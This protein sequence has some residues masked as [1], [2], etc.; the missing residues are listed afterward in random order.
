MSGAGPGGPVSFADVAVYFS[1]EE[2]GRLRPAQ[3]A[4]YRD[5]MRETYGHLDVLGFPGPKPALISWM[6]QETWDSDANCPEGDWE[7]A[8]TCEA[9]AKSKNK[10]IRKTPGEEEGPVTKRLEDVGQPTTR[11]GE[12][13]TQSAKLPS[14]PH[15][16]RPPTS[17]S[18]CVSLSAPRTD[19]RHG[20]NIC[21]KHFAWRS[22]LVEHIY[23]HTGEKP[24]HCPDCDKGFSQTSSLSKHRA[25]HRGE[26][27]HRCPDCGRAFTQ[28]SA[29][30]THLRVH[31]GEKP[32]QCA[33]CGRRFS[34]SSA[35]SQH[36]RVHSGETP[37]SCADCGRAFAHN[38]DLRRHQ[39]THTGEKP[40]PCP[41]CGRCFRQS[42][43]MVA[44]RRTHSGERPY[45]CPEC[46]RR[47]SQK[48]AV[49]KH[50]WIHRPGAGG[51]RGRLTAVLPMQ[52][53]S[54][55]EDLDPPVGFQHYPE[56]FQECGPSSELE[57]P[58]PRAPS[59]QSGSTG[60]S[61]RLEETVNASTSRR[62][63]GRGLGALRPIAGPLRKKEGGAARPSC[64][65]R[66]SGG[67]VS[68]ATILDWREG[69]APGDSA[70]RHAAAEPR[71]KA[72]G[73][74][75]RR[76][77]RPGVRRKGRRRRL[78][79]EPEPGQDPVAPAVPR[80]WGLL[81]RSPGTRLHGPSDQ[82]A[83][84][85]TA[86]L[87]SGTERPGPYPQPPQRRLLFL[88]HLLRLAPRARGLSGSGASLAGS[89][90]IT[91]TSCV[92][93][94]GRGLGSR[95]PARGW[96]AGPPTPGSQE[97]CRGHRAVDPRVQAACILKAD[98]GLGRKVGT[99]A[100]TRTGSRA[101]PAV[102]GARRSGD[103]WWT[104]GAPGARTPREL[105][106]GG[107]E[108]RL[109]LF[110]SKGFPRLL[111]SKME[112]ETRPWGLDP[113]SPEEPESQRGT[114]TGS[115][116]GRRK[117]V[118]ENEEEIPQ[119]ED[120]ENED[121]EEIPFGVEPQSPGFDEIPEVPPSPE[122][123][124]PLDLSLED[125]PLDSYTEGYEDQPP[126]DL[127][128]GT[129][130][131][132][133]SGTLLTDPRFEIL[134]ENPLNL[135]E[136]IHSQPRRGGGP[137][138]QGRQPPRPN[139]CGICGKSFGRGSTLIQHQ[140]IHTG[141]KPYK[142][143]VCGKAFSQSSDLIKHQRTH[144]GERP[145]KCPR[146]G[147]AFA[148]SSYLL[149]HQRTHTGQKPYKCPYCGKAFGD[150]S[151]LLRHQRTH[152][153]ERP[154]SCPDCG[155]CYSQNSSLR[156]H[157]RVH[158]GQRPYSCGICGKSFSQRSALTPHARSHTREKP[159]KCPECGKRFGQSSV[160]AIHARTHLPGRTYSCP[161][162]G[163]TFNRSSTLIQ[164]Q[165]SH[166]GERPYKCAICGK[167]FCRSS[168]LLQHHRVH[169]G[170]RPYKCDD[171]G[172]AFSQSSDLIRHQRT[173]AAGRR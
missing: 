147:K 1:P 83:D 159:F 141:E 102:R 12:H 39:R 65:L 21:G 48:S 133:P 3:R 145:Y 130:F 59:G 134:Q 6:E 93:G 90:R 60:G 73:G 64:S 106:L 27:P 126:R 124:D 121:V 80:V 155:K 42:S 135:T 63:N 44:H 153:H 56:I 104:A 26:R 113:Q 79:A 108:G 167:G 5:V 157:Q 71:W 11:T 139:I 150:S 143:E 85:Q 132:M 23:T 101:Y 28:R 152:S 129:T 7:K 164:H 154:Y 144:T 172:K 15:Q 166:T 112:R 114:P 84:R 165:R 115:E 14:A 171:C 40:F 61:S 158:T 53:V 4:L 118:S 87:G 24:F 138:G 62:G 86:G 98:G 89:W 173:H 111:V 51:R 146:C 52:L 20:C 47:F 149:R 30:T 8:V 32:Y 142:C 96:G 117:R 161:D 2:W 120:S 123:K 82:Q 103:P 50:Q 37:F 105:R 76:S 136:T 33:D 54:V 57:D 92:G 22:T 78:I 29:L 69:Q 10:V 168:T 116:C 70:D 18:L 9:G 170:E 58:A 77:R 81:L 100:R 140:R 13:K 45:S 88:Q 55:Q 94:G 31:T 74:A 148:D 125:D 131:E 35:L 34:Q 75:S 43:E 99:S 46:G 66:P 16:G 36:H 19:K 162:C 95:S 107:P 109:L 128:L 97:G 156:S 68:L 151:Y 110:F 91:D 67:A 169:S 38:S 119:Q 122:E 160:L 137:R 25:I 163:K 127:P 41:D 49:A 72:G 17:P